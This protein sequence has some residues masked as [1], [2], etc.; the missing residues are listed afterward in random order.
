M[1]VL[2]RDIHQEEPIYRNQNVCA[3]N[4]I[5]HTESQ[6]V[7]E[8]LCNCL[9]NQNPGKGINCLLLRFIAWRYGVHI[10]PQA[11]P[12]TKSIVECRSNSNHHTLLLAPPSYYFIL[13]ELLIIPSHYTQSS[14]SNIQMCQ[15]VYNIQSPEFA[16]VW[17]DKHKYDK[18]TQTHVCAYIDKY[19]TIQW[20]MVGMFCLVGVLWKPSNIISVQNT[21]W[22]NDL[23]IEDLRFIF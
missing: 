7:R 15:I 2:S 14:V 9:C 12:H 11:N 1:G 22:F 5:H 6:I 23:I 8:R 20:I 13:F 16:F 17:L 10:F 3:L 18:Q 21:L 19:S 4:G